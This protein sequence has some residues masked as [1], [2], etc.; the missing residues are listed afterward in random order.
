MKQR[1]REFS[2]MTFAPLCTNLTRFEL[3]E[4]KSS[5][6]PC[7]GEAFLEPLLFRKLDSYRIRDSDVSLPWIT[8]LLDHNPH[9]K[10]EAKISLQEPSSIMRYI[11]AR[12]QLSTVATQ[13]R[14]SKLNTKFRREILGEIFLDFVV[15]GPKPTL[16]MLP[17][18]QQPDLNPAAVHPHP[19][20]DEHN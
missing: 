11:H 19:M 1:I 4:F 9:P 13:S 12:R 7:L 16:P 6:Y 2:L 5:P 15:Q 18:L 20:Q 10:G 3:V 8:N 17:A 14:N